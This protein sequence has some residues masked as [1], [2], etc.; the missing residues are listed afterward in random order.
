MKTELILVERARADEAVQQSDERYRDLLAAVTDYVYSVTV[1]D[2]RAVSTLH[3]PG[4]EAVT[5]YTPAEFSNNPVLWFQMV[6][7][8]D[9]PRVLEQ[10]KLILQGTVPPGLEHRIRHKNGSIR[11]VRNT[12]VPHRRR[13]GRLMGYDGVVSDIT[14]RKRAEQLLSLQYA[15]MRDLSQA[16][17]LHEAMTRILQT[18]CQTFGCF[19]WNLAV[20]WGVD[21]QGNALTCHETWSSRSHGWEKFETAIGNSSIK[22]GQGLPGRVWAGGES[23]WIADLAR[24]PDPAVLPGGTANGVRGALAFPIRWDEQFLGVIGLFG[25]DSNE[26]DAQVME[27][28]AGVGTQIGQFMERRKI[29]EQQRLSEARLQAILDHS[30]AIIHMKDLQGR[31]LL[32]NRRYEEL[33]CVKRTEVLGKTAFDVFGQDT[34]HMLRSHDQQVIAAHTPIEFE[35]TIPQEDGLHTYIAVK[36][37]LLDANGSPYATCGVSTDITERKRAEHALEESQVRLALVIRGSN[38]GIWDWN[39]LTNEVYFSPRWKSMLGYEEK[40]LGDTFE[41]WVELLHPEDREHA[42]KVV[43]AYLSGQATTYELE[44]RLRHKDGSYRWILARGVALRDANGK[45]IRMAGS[46]VDLTDRRQAEEQLK[47][48]Y[49]ELTQNEEELKRTVQ[50]LQKS[51]QELQATQLQLIQAAKME[52]VGTLAAGV[53]HEVKN[54]LQTIIMGLDYLR[55]NLPDG[56]PNLDFVFNDMRDAVGRA[57]AIIRELLQFSAASDFSFRPEDLNEVVSRSLWLVQAEAVASRITVRRELA[58]SLPM[59]EIDRGKME[60]VLINLFLNAMQA[61]SQGG[62]LTVSTRLGHLPEAPSSGDP[63]APRVMSGEPA[64]IV[65]VKDTGGGIPKADLPK[66]FDPF[67]TTKAVGVGTGLGL[68]IVKKIIDLHRGTISIENAPG[69]GVRVTLALRAKP[70]HSNERS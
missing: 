8:E 48:A 58:E 50:A 20:F 53:A 67:F 9:R 35:E 4:C 27:A 14:E 68:S 25:G 41:V 42:M 43:Q 39:L 54:P 7:P 60:Q 37:P 33:F 26:P 16:S 38:D 66:V 24:E 47:R 57:N 17:T 18:L 70:E 59:V 61:M 52:S 1:E 23:V 29:Q 31:Y 44:H 49:A 51:H 11:W 64:I 10:A 46:H 15:V 65:E 69:E 63:G 13:D 28:L 6:C 22:L 62:I 21:P 34:A 45:P 32:V 40:D 3:G 55:R 36:F 5:G 2:G 30:P 56:N 12:A 19:P